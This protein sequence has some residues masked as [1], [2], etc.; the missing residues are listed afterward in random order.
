MS[1]PA[2]PTIR[3]MLKGIDI[4]QLER[5][6]GGWLQT[7]G[8]SGEPIALDGKVLRGTRSIGASKDTLQLVSAFGHHSAM[9]MNQ[10]VAASS[11]MSDLR[12]PVIVTGH[13]GRS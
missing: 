4:E 3:R 12:I 7:Q 8:D 10:V 13:S 9:V 11:N 2:E 5:Q 1:A 6:L